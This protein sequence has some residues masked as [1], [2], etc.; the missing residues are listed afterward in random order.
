M[1]NS[2]VILYCRVSTD[3]QAEKG[4]SIKQ[5]EE[6]LTSYCKK[7]QYDVIKVYKEDHTAKNFNRPEWRELKT[8]V[9]ANKNQIAKILYTR[10]D[11]F[12]RSSE[13]AYPVLA[14]FRRMGIELNAIEQLL[15]FSQSSNK[16]L[17]ALHLAQGEIERDNISERTLK[18]TRQAKKDGYYCGRAPYGYDNHRDEFKKPILKANH[19]SVFVKM[20]FEEVAK[21]IEPVEEIRKRLSK[22]GM[23]LQKSA[24]SILL[25][26]IVYAAKIVVPEYQ[27]EPMEIVDGKFEPIIDLNT[28]YTVQDV[29][30]GKRWHGL[31]SH[32]NYDFPMRDFLTCEV[33]GRQITG[34]ISKGRSNKY[35][36]Y[37]CRNK[38][39]TRVS[40]GNTHGFVSNLLTD[41]QINENVK[42]LFKDIL[43]DV[44]SQYN[45]NR[46]KQLENA[47]I[48]QK[49]IKENIIQAEDM[50]LRNE[51]QSDRFNSIVNR[52][53][54]D[55]MKINNEIEVLSLNSGSIKEY[56]K[57][58]LELLANLDRMFLES[59]YDGK[60]ILAGSLFNEKLIFGN[61]GC[62]TAETNKVVELLTRFNKVSVK[63]KKEKAAFLGDF[64]VTVP[65]AG[66]EP[67]RFPT[68]V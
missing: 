66:V 33:C 23:T 19:K 21:G 54:T 27:K 46:T 18:G 61:K 3:E 6:S 44:D 48:K 67:A 47:L 7:M 35:G 1:E 57:D 40:I 63:T 42:E 28:F 37:H 68:G 16:V 50:L 65:R 60:R 20:A 9:K 24:F 8:F 51:I 15:D 29:F 45:G 53:N 58:G 31:K 26:N 5:Q 25:K 49:T 62:R 43:T 59:D 52:L 10:W 36:Y 38:C 11:R 64:S 34:S 4:H 17:L 14:E 41:I 30:R 22:S 2:K 55:L 32:I 13:Q 56:I 39:K 12:S